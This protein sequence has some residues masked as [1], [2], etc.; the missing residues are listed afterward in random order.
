MHCPWWVVHLNNFTCPG[1]LIS[2]VCHENTVSGVPYVSSGQLM[3]GCYCPGG[4]QPPRIPGR[5][6]WQLG[7]CSQFGGR[8]HLCVWDCSI[9]LPS[10]SGF[11]TPAFLPLRVEGP[12]CSY[13]LSFH[14]FSILCSLNTPGCGL[15][16]FQGKF[17]FF[18]SLEI[19]QFRLLSHVC[20]LRLS[21][22]HSGLIFGASDAAGN[23][24]PCSCLLVADMNIWA[25]GAG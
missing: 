24:L 18:V 13:L 3:L 5:H 16:P 1:C 6:G 25:T 20:S 22:G 7:T 21:S 15:E 9:P 14:I 11:H 4:C 10:C 12:I 19:P 23:S 8:C 2:W 17:F